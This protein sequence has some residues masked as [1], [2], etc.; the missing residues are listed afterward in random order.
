M[1]DKLYEELSIF[2]S[3]TEEHKDILSF[4]I[5]GLVLFITFDFFI[6]RLLLENHNGEHSHLMIPLYTSL[7]KL[8]TL[9]SFA[10]FVLG[11]F[12]ASLHKYYKCRKK[13]ING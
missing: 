11:S 13:I 10:V 1:K 5:I 7:F 9:I 4:P 8:L 6:G 3:I 2:N 12:G